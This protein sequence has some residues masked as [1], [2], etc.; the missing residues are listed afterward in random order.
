MDWGGEWFQGDSAKSDPSKASAQ[1]GNLSELRMVVLLTS[2]SEPLHHD[3]FMFQENWRSKIRVFFFFLTV[4]D[5]DLT[6]ETDAALANA[7][8]VSEQSGGVRAR[9]TLPPARPVAL[10]ARLVAAWRRRRRKEGGRERDVSRVSNLRVSSTRQP[11]H[12]LLKT[13]RSDFQEF[14]VSRGNF[15][16]TG[17][18]LFF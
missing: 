11:L 14:C 10:R 12:P 5:S 9:H 15:L 16:K 1:T 3:A 6:V 17:C 18:F 13:R 8:A 2:V 7:L 4:A